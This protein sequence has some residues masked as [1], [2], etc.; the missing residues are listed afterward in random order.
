MIRRTLTILSLLGLLLSVGLW[1]ITYLHIGYERGLN[2]LSAGE[3]ELIWIHSTRV[4]QPGAGWWFIGFMD[5]DTRW[6][7]RILVREW[8]WNVHLPLWIP[9]AMFGSTLTFISLPFHRCRKHKKLGLCVKCGYDLRGSK[10]RCPECGEE[11]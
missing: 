4:E 8:G 2:Y 3:G 6:I 7:P 10:E 5:F 1:G 11:R 9:C